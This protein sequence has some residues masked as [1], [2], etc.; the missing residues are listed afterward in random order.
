MILLCAALACAVTGSVGARAQ[1][2]SSLP[3]PP[4]QVVTG[5]VYKTPSACQPPSS[6]PSITTGA[7]ANLYVLPSSCTAVPSFIATAPAAMVVTSVPTQY[8]RFYCP[9]C[10]PPSDPNRAFIADAST[11]RGLTPAQIQDVLALPAV[12]T[13][14]TIVLVPAGTCILVGMGA[15]AFG[16][17]GG[18]AQEWIAGTPSGPNC[19]GLQYLPASDYILRQPIGAYALLYGPNA[20]GGNA[21]AVAAALDRGPYPAPF[22]G[23]AGLYNGLDLLN[24]GDPAPLRSALLQLDGEVHASIRTV[25]LGDSLYLRDAVLGRLRQGLVGGAQMAALVAGGPVF[26]SVGEPSTGAAVHGGAALAYAGDRKAAFPVHPAAPA[27]ALSQAIVWT[28]GV[29]AWGHIAGE[30]DAAGLSRNL[31]GLFAGI[32]RR[33]G[34]NGLAG[35]AGGFT[36]SSLSIGDRSSSADIATAH[37]AGYAGASLGPW[38]L[39]GAGSASFSTIDADRTIAFSTFFDSVTARYRAT[40]TQAFGEIGYAAAFGAVA[41]EPFVGAAYVHLQ[42][43]GFTEGGGTGFAGLTSSGGADDLGFTTLGSRAAVAYDL[44]YGM[45]LTLRASAAWQHGV[46]ALVPTAALAFAGNSAP[47][48]V[49]GVPL[50]RDAALVQAGF[51]LQLGRQMIV[52]VA[53]SGNLSDRAQDNSVR[54]QLSWRF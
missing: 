25:M 49:A 4:G 12:P 39:R 23:M 33:F 45:M 31:G 53:Y 30:G 32:D 16:G 40:T 8:V 47:F 19:F 13:M 52:S 27:A 41:V 36:N 5:I 11:V 15:P 6:L 28:Q 3:L 42:T 7:D 54:G 38:T 51:D 37:V 2:V 9:T 10:T 29:G 48:T 21:G 34:A 44:A 43:G 35:V 14:Q 50:A 1:S 17:R 24:F 22:S 26:A 18:P 20:G 46:G